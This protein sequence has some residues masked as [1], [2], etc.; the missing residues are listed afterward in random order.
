MGT[1]LWPLCK[2]SLAVTF[3]W[4]FLASLALIEE[5]QGARILH[6]ES[7]ITPSLNPAGAS[8]SCAAHIDYHEKKNLIPSGL[9]QA[10]SKIESGRKDAKGQIVA[11]PWTVNAEGQ[12]YFYPTKEA[13]IAAVQK[14]QQKGMKSIDIGCMQ[15]NLH[16]HPHAFKDLNDGFDPEINVAYA[17]SFI[18][19]LKNAHTSWHQAIAHYHSANPV[20]HIP[21][22][23]NV[24]NAWNRDMKGDGVSLALANFNQK[25]ASQRLHRP[26]KTLSLTN[27]VYT[28]SSSSWSVRRI[29]GKSSPH[30]RRVSG[31]KTLPLS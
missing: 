14:M 22:R 20:H 17:T 4:M 13:A 8:S 12:G 27:A 15:V 16:H 31:R 25:P 23:K 29:V 26:G 24:M 10:I 6:M 9:L 7:Q 19:R 21:Y 2:L 11:W 18:K 1:P 30:L 3:L 5:S 28:P